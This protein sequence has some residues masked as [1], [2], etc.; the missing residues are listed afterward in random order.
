MPAIGDAAGAA[1]ETPAW[2][3]NAIG[4]RAG[5]AGDLKGISDGAELTPVWIPS[6]SS[7][8]VWINDG[9]HRGGTGSVGSAAASICEQVWQ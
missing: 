6:Y 1:R 8:L 2:I 9:V 7:G 4:D 3:E 5:N